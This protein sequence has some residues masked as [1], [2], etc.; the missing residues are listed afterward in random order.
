MSGCALAAI[1]LAELSSVVCKE[2]H[3]QL[4]VLVSLCFGSVC[5][6]IRALG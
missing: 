2:V 4:L 6:R 3:W 5:L 1:T